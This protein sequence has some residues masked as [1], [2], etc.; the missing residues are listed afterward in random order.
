M[1]LTSRVASLCQV[2]TFEETF[3]LVFVD[4][5]NAVVE[6]K[7]IK[8]SSGFIRHNVFILIRLS[9]KPKFVPNPFFRWQ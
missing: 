7:C 9:N 6:E 3:G 1:P 5:S 2:M 8:S 4:C